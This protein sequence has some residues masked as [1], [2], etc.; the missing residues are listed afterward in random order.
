MWPIDLFP[1]KVA[2]EITSAD[3]EG[4]LRRLETSQITLYHVEDVGQLVLRLC[5]DR[6]DLRRVRTILRDRGDQVRIRWGRGIYRTVVHTIRRPVLTVGCMALLCLT[7]YL[8]TRVLIIE[9]EGA[10]AV[11]VR[12]IISEISAHGVRVGTSRRAI[13][14]EQVKNSL[15][16]AVPELQWVGVNTYGCR[17][18]ISVKERAIRD[19]QGERKGVGHVTSLHDAVVSQITVT[20]GTPMCVPGDPVTSGQVLIS[21]FSDR[22]L[23][24]RGEVAQGEVFGETERSVTAYF[25]EKALVRSG[26]TVSKKNFCL[27]IGKKRIFFSKGSGI[28]DATCGKMYTEHYMM[29]PGGIRLPIGIGVEEVCDPQVEERSIPSDQA[30]VI[31]TEQAE[32]QLSR[33]MISG[34][35]L[36]REV[37]FSETDG[38]Y[39]IMGRYRC[40]EMIGITH[41]EENFDRY[42]TDRADRE[43]G[44]S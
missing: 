31:M 15:L 40:R 38:A 6:R 44:E 18:V 2:L 10:V 12:R 29:L 13:R 14:S 36:S 32:R 27:V 7:M 21:G 39:L 28:S 41:I 22:G 35:I 11:P 34:S 20:K 24:V 43:R 19:V 4:T 42:E 5:V 9:V 8:P 26:E 16:Q 23:F 37:S 30:E 3:R 25:P 1:G 17:A 33:R